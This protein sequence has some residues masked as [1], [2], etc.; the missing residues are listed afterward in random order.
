MDRTH[1]LTEKV[2]STNKTRLLANM[3]GITRTIH[4]VTDQDYELHD[5]DSGGYVILAITGSG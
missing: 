4:H 5:Y 1:Y 2:S 3:A